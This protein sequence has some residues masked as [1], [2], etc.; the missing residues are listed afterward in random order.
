M[1]PGASAAVAHAGGSAPVIL[2]PRDSAL[3]VGKSVR[4]RVIAR[5]DFQAIVGRRDV[6]GRFGR[7][8]RGV[9]SAVLRRGR[10]FGVGFNRLVVRSGRGRKRRYVAVTF[11]AGQRTRGALHVRV[12]RQTGSG[13]AVAISGPAKRRFAL[14]ATM[15][16]GRRVNTRDWVEGLRTPST[17]WP[18]AQRSF[19]ARF[20]ADNGARY[21][22]NRLMVTAW[23]TSG[24][25]DRVSLR[26]DVGRRSALASAGEGRRTQIRGLVVLDGRKTRV[27]DHRRV[28][29][30]WTI[31]S[32]PKGSGARLVAADSARPRLRPDKPGTY[33]IRLTAWAGRPGAGDQALAAAAG[34]VDETTVQATVPTPPIG[35]PI[36]TIAPGG[37]IEIG[38]Q[39]YT[40]PAGSWAQVLVLDRQTLQ[41]ISNQG[42]GNASSV[43]DGAVGQNWAA[44]SAA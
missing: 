26:I 1:A 34:S 29:Y 17:T 12:Q 7:A 42:I 19:V 15:L 32:A 9:R 24:R 11:V 43:T 37:G 28:L 13:I 18:L 21:G 40:A 22:R 23:N 44:S 14:V 20:G 30:R 16:N 35:V 6:A 4:V 39:T 5:R 25:F 36:R 3:V 33:R 27:P 41:V 8:R 10:D 31:I 38:G 2:V